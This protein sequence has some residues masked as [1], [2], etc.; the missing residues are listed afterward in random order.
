MIDEIFREPAVLKF[1]G[2]SHATLWERVKEGV[3]PKPVKLGA[4]AVGRFTSDLVDHQ[5]KL[6]AQVSLRN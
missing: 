5:K 2:W 4:R 3:F 1:T 6:R